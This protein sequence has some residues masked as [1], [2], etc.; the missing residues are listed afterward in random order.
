MPKNH[1]LGG[2]SGDARK[3]ALKEQRAVES[4]EMVQ[5]VCDEIGQRRPPPLGTILTCYRCKHQCLLPVEI[6]RLS[7]RVI[8]CSVCGHTVEL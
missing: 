1:K 2:M 3:A 6:E 4:S 5:R 8:E 7:H